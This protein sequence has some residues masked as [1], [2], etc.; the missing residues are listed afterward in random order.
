MRQVEKRGVDGSIPGRDIY[1]YIELFACVPFFIA[2]R[3][4]Y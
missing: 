3:S 1:F 4:P 2:Q